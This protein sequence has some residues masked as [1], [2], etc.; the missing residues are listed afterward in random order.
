MAKQVQPGVYKGTILTV[1]P[2][3]GQLYVAARCNGIE[4]LVEVFFP[5]PMLCTARVGGSLAVHVHAD[6]S[7]IVKFDDEPAVRAAGHEIDDLS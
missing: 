3:D 1:E 2:R 4:D 6:R 5:L 7:V